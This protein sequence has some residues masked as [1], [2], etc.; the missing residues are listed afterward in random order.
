MAGPN[1]KG[2]EHMQSRYEY[3]YKGLPL[4]SFSDG[5]TVLTEH[6]ICRVPKNQEVDVEMQ[7]FHSTTVVGIQLSFRRSEL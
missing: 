2:T 1:L 3:T 5:R 6:R 4:M 7:T